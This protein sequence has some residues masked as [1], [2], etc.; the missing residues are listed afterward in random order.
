[1]AW[2]LEQEEEF[3]YPGHGIPVIDNMPSVRH[4][5]VVPS[6]KGMIPCK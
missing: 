5:L 1:M 6:C 3:A 4:K 2:S